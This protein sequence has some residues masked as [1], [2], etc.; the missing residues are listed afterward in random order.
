MYIPG[1]V[2]YLVHQLFSKMDIFDG[3]LEA[4]Q[5]EYFCSDIYNPTA[6]SRFAASCI[7]ATGHSALPIYVVHLAFGFTTTLT[8]RK[9]KDPRDYSF[10]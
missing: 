8:K 2:Y 7:S 5:T 4:Q 3:T 9:S 1:N 6:R 10:Q